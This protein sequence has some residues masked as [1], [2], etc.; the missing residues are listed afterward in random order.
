MNFTVGEMV[1]TK[2]KTINRDKIISADFESNEIQ[3]LIDFIICG[4]FDQ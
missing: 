1:S 3:I 2:Y 4:N